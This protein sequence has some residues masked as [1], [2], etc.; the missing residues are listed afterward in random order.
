MFTFLNLQ[1]YLFDYFANFI[2]KFWLLEFEDFKN[3]NWILWTIEEY[4]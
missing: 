3:R 1:I 2:M 4:F